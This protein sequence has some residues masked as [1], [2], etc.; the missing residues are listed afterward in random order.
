MKSALQLET[1]RAG[2]K[3]EYGTSQIGLLDKIR[4]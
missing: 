1:A 3:F 2:M 4:M